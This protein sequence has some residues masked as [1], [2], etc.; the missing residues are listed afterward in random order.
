MPDELQTPGAR[1]TIVS[2]R[3][4]VRSLGDTSGLVVGLS[5]LISLI[6]ALK[7]LIKPLRA[8]NSFKEPRLQN[9][10]FPSLRPPQQKQNK[11]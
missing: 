1:E 11:G 7:G 6:R 4:L 10:L 9:S 3:G 2:P 8:Q 5:P